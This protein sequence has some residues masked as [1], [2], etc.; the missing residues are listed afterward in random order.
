VSN[1]GHFGVIVSNQN[2][3]IKAGDFIMISAISG[4][5]MR[6]DSK[7]DTQVV[8]K[9]ASNFNGTSN[10]IGSVEV[11]DTVGRKTTVSLGRIQLNAAISHN[12]LFAKNA[13]YVP[14]GL[15]KIAQAVTDKPVSAAR[16]YLG[17]VIIVVAAFIAGSTVFS[18]VRSG[19]ISIGRNPLSKKSIIKSLIQTVM[20]GLMI[21]I[22][23]IF[24]VYLLLKL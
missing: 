2:G 22:V 1:V 8:G 18:G 12:P 20:A 10:V 19:M 24:A 21:F 6:A 11:S 14:A 3:P 5:G 23:G 9:A 15:A 13:D 17:L 4:V 16:V 7:T